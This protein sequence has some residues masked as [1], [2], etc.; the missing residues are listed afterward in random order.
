MPNAVAGMGEKMTMVRSLVGA[1]ICTALTVTPF[2]TV[3]AVAEPMHFEVIRNGG[4]CANCSYTQAA[5]EITSDT[6][7]QFE[8]FVAS[9]KFGI[10]TVRLNSP[11][12]NLFGG[13]AFGELFRTR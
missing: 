13:I 2:T 1:A 7:K 6:P 3:G 8:T 10:G 11:G 9:Q 5:G 4:N 12:G